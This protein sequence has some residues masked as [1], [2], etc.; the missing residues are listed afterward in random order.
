MGHLQHEFL[1]TCRETGRGREREREILSRVSRKYM[2][3]KYMALRRAH[4]L[5]LWDPGASTPLEET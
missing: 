5:K 2:T 1:P 3:G 4:R